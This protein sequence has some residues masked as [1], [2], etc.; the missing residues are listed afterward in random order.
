[1]K[2]IPTFSG[3]VLA[4][5]V[6]ALALAVSPVAAQLQSASSAGLGTANNYLAQ[7]RGFAALS[8]D[9]ATLG[10]PG[11]PGFSLAVLPIGLQ[12][13]LAPVTLTDLKDYQGKTIP[14]AT[15]N[16]W[17]NEIQASGG[18]HVLAGAQITG[19]SLTAGHFGL[20]VSTMGHARASLTEP[21]AQLLLFGNAGRTGAPSDF[22]LRGSSLDAWAVTTVGAGVGIPLHVRIGPWA[23]QSFAVGAT[24]K[25]SVGNVLLMGREEGGTVSSDPLQVDVQFPVIQTDTTGKHLNNG[26]GIGLDLGAAWQAG[27]WTAGLAIRNVFNT[28]QWSASKLFFRPGQALFNQTTKTTDFAAVRAQ[29]TAAAAPLLS[30]VANQKFNPVLA[31]SASYDVSSM[32]TV[33]GEIDN[34]FGNGIDVGPK[35]HVGAGVEVHPLSVL[36]LRGGLAK[37]TG[38]GQFAAGATLALGPLDLSGAYLRQTGSAVDGDLAQFTLSFGGH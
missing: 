28:F 20:Q 17:L 11:G 35:S 1:M 19:L 12:G 5:S 3:R 24:L 16:R 14:D 15:K 29:D 25:Y 4:A 27:P 32:V 8:L 23:H 26:T 37:I 18:Q 10:L 33:M 34:R 30:E 7:A 9:P 13:G 6:V 38:G 2:R 31:V 22:S 21:V 36:Y